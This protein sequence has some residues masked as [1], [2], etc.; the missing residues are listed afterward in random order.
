VFDAGLTP[1]YM[2]GM[3][4]NQEIWSKSVFA[5]RNSSYVKSM[6][7]NNYTTIFGN[8]AFKVKPMYSHVDAAINSC[9]LGYSRLTT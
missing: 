1:V 8:S 7:P 2:I 6:A 9:D 4:T 5:P 3:H